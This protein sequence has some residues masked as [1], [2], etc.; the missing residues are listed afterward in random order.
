MALTA[1]EEKYCQEYVLKLDKTKAAIAA[2]YSKRSAKE[3]GYENFTKPHIKQRIE[4]IRQEI[5]EKLGIDE[6]SVLTEMASLSYWNIQDFM[7]EGNNVKDLSQLDRD[8]LKPVTG[9]KVKRTIITVG[10]KTVESTI[11]DLKMADKRA[12]LQ[13]LGRHLGVYEKDNN[14][15]AI[16]IKVS[17]K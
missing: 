6:H 2:G 16:K 11:I 15:K 4:E 7:D 5:K 8:M 10:D 12:S 3:I 9:I 13:D 17:R 14:Q 1:R